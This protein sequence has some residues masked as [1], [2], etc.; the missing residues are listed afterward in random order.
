[1]G[2]FKS[3]E[4]RRI[5]RNLQVRK[6]VTQIRRQIRDNEKHETDYV[7]KAKRA[8]RLGWSNQYE[9]LK[10]AIKK[11][12][13]VKVQLERQLLALESAMQVK[14]QAEGHAEFAR[15]MA[16]VSKSIS[17][18]FGTTDLA[19]TQVNFEKALA[20]AENLEAR[21]DAFL[22]MTSESMF[23]YE[24][25]AEG[26]VVTD[27]DIERMLEDEVAHDERAGGGVSTDEGRRIE[28]DLA[29]IEK[30]IGESRK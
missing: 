24:S 26:E 27:A 23:G 19:K 22:D 25:T 2:L 12:A 29:S 10:K 17:E 16:A 15:G 13:T 8:R 28:E 30:A 6:A 5:E 14:E 3:R 9:F 18:V 4:E 7:T 1:M 21:M 11:T 20:Q